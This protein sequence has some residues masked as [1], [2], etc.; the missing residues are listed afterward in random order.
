VSLPA[1][2][3]RDRGNDERGDP[4]LI[5]H[6][7]KMKPLAVPGLARAMTHRLSAQIFS[8]WCFFRRSSE[9]KIPAT[10]SSTTPIVHRCLQTVSPVHGIVGEPDAPRLF[11]CR[12]CKTLFAFAD[13]SLFAEEAAPSGFPA[14]ST[15]QRA[16]RH[17][18]S[19]ELIQAPIRAI[20]VSSFFFF[21]F[22]CRCAM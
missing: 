11:I 14:H 13:Q 12:S 19:F 15:C 3:S 2:R 4:S 21:F 18:Y 17:G 9:D 16:S 7:K 5:L 22:C 6:R 8:I 10:R 1:I 20:N